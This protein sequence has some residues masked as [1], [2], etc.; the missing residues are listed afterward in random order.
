MQDV[1]P[2]GWL[3]FA[4]AIVVGFGLLTSVSVFPGTAGPVQ[5][6]ADLVFWPIDGAQS[7][8]APETR[9]VLAIAGGI[10]AG[11]GV[12]LWFIVARIYPREPE[13][14][15]SA[16]LISVSTWFV[17]DSVGS[18]VAGAPLNAFLNIGFLLMFAIP[19]WRPVRPAQ[20]GSP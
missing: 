8:A 2:N 12:L 17:I 20:V 19:L 15:R 14:A 7:L 11:W 6:L 16:I 3:K 13:L 1:A 18:V 10:S 9:L 5:L 4:C